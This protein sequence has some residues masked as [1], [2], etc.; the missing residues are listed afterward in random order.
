MARACNPSYS[1][2]W[3]RRIAWTQEVEVAVSRDRA[4]ALQPGN[5]SETQKKKKSNMKCTWPNFHIIV[6]Q[7]LWR[8]YMGFSAEQPL[9]ILVPRLNMMILFPRITTIPIFFCCSLV[10]ISTHSSI[11]RFIKGSNPHNIPW[12]CLPPFNFNDNFLSKNFFNLG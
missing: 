3:G 7:A 5:K 11:T 2:G 8:E 10:A 9:F 12:T 4:I 1:G 6:K